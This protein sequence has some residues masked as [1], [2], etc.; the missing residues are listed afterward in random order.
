MDEF[1]RTYSNKDTLEVA[2]PYFWDKFEKDNYSIWFCDYQYTKDLGKIF[3][4]CNL[5]SGNVPLN[6]DL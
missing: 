6:H 5:V 1:K 2:I 3:M 4:T